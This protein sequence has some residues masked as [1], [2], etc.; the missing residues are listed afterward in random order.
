MTA[1]TAGKIKRAVPVNWN[2]PGLIGISH[3]LRILPPAPAGAAKTATACARAVS[4]AD[5]VFA[6][7][8]VSGAGFLG[9]GGC[10]A[11]SD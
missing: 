6:V 1:N 4:V 10:G 5:G 7:E 11:R 3:D 2:G 9:D 8:R